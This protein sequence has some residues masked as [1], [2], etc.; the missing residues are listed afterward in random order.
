M[1]VCAFVR[2]CICTCVYIYMCVY[3]R[4]YVRVCV[5]IYMCVYVRAYVRV[6][7]YTVHVCVCLQRLLPPVHQEVS[8]EAEECP[9]VLF[10]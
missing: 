9:R 3:V 6:C 2:A 1:H 10:S 4:A 8:G 5:Y 7:V